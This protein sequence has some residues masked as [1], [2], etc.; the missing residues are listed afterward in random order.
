MDT[1]VYNNFAISKLNLKYGVL[2][3]K[4]SNTVRETGF[5][6]KFKT[7]VS[8]LKRLEFNLQTS[9]LVFDAMTENSY[10]LICLLPLPNTLTAVCDL[11][12]VCS[13]SQ[14]PFRLK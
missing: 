6:V 1:Q 12:F 5:A 3:Y 2:V 4:L 8:G 13:R 7:A 14:G 9:C 11:T 10:S